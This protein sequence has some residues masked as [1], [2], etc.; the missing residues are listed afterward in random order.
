[1]GE[2]L[3]Y[4]LSWILDLT[5]PGLRAAWGNLGCLLVSILAAGLLVW[6]LPAYV[7]DGPGGDWKTWL[8]VGP[9]A[10]FAVV[11][12]VAGTYGLARGSRSKREE[13]AADE[14]PEDQ[15]P[16]ERAIMEPLVRDTKALGRAIPDTILRYTHPAT[17][18]CLYCAETLNARAIVCW[19]C[20]RNIYR[21]RNESTSKRRGQGDSE[22]LPGTGSGGEP[23]LAGNGGQ[24]AECTH[25]G[26]RNA[27]DSAF[28]GECGAV[29]TVAEQ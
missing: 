11:V 7:L 16:A 29:L 14:S 5:V 18:E 9:L 25:C 15:E 19:N 22:G 3:G 8:I 20:G 27:T 1:M 17:K 24:T 13:E 21:L 10:T 4:V 6:F 28:C 2:I 23:I 12:M 26:T